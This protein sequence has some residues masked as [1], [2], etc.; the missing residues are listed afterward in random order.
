MCK[1]EWEILD[2][3]KKDSRNLEYY[4]DFYIKIRNEK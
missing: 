4:K 1:I 2:I 3:F